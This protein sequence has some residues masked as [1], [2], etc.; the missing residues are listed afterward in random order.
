MCWL[1]AADGGIHRILGIEKIGPIAGDDPDRGNVNGN[2]EVIARMSDGTSVRAFAFYNDE[3]SVTKDDFVD[4]SLAQARELKFQ[5]DREDG[6]NELLR[7]DY[8][9][10]F[11]NGR[12]AT[13]GALCLLC[14]KSH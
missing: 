3:L 14:G 10:V 13:D 5:R 2:W 9:N 11:A 7:P 8:S 6:W 1:A 12:D 4:L